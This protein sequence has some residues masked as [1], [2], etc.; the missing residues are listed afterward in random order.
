MLSHSWQ[1]MTAVWMPVALG[2]GLLVVG[3]GAGWVL[4]ERA[5]LL[6]VRLVEWWVRHVVLP[7]IRCPSWWRRAAAIFVNNAL[8][9]TALLVVGHWPVAPIVAISVVGVS[10]GIGLRV[11]SDR[12]IDPTPA[13]PTLTAR[14]GLRVRIGVALNLLEPP[15]I[16]LT[17]GLSLGHRAIPLNAVQVWETFL[18]WVIPATFLAAAG[19]AL[20]LGV[21]QD[22]CGAHEHPLPHDTESDSDS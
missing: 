13:K 14:K 11:L 18:L 12:L 19:E 6:P 15:A 20:W 16:M 21:S 3:T 9:L 1:V 17:V 8:I 22:T 4:A 5:S 2:T 10:L 7:L